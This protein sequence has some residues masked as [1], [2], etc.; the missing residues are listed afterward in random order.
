MVRDGEPAP[1]DVPQVVPGDLVVVGAGDQVV[2]DGPAWRS[3][4]AE[5]GRADLTRRGRAGHD[6]PPA[7]R[8]AAAPYAVEGTGALRAEAVGADT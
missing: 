2:A 5:A 1:V 3:E 7:S 4:R 8:C 6:A